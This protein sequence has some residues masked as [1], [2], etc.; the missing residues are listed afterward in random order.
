MKGR[1]NLE[2]ISA[3][4][5]ALNLLWYFSIAVFFFFLC[6]LHPDVGDVFPV[7]QISMYEFLRVCIMPHN[8]SVAY[9]FMNELATPTRKIHRLVT[10]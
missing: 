3:D 5:Y 4:V 6:G 10:C 9:K 8:V 2:H 7:T 1:A